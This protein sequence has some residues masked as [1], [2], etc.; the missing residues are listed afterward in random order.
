MPCRGLNP[1]HGK[2]RAIYKRLGQYILGF[3]GEGF[4]LLIM[5]NNL[6]F[7]PTYKNTMAGIAIQR[8]YDNWSVFPL[9]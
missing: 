9:K 8:F 2:L 1:I 5:C 7:G 6:L 3:S 4:C